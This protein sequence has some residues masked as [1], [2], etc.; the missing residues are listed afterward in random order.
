[1]VVTDRWQRFTDCVVSPDT[2]AALAEHCAE[3]LVHGVDVEGLRAGIEVRGASIPCIVYWVHGI[4]VCGSAHGGRA[5]RV[6]GSAFGVLGSANWG[7]RSVYWFSA[8]GFSALAFGAFGFGALG[9]SAFGLGA[10]GSAARVLRISCSGRSC[11]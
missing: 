4:E 9:F 2:L 11:Q 6:L 5:F 8:L 3:F 1:V 10:L 7:Q